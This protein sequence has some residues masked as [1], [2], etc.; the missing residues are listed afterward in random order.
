[1][2][3]GIWRFAVALSDAAETNCNIG[4]HTCTLAHTCTRVSLTCI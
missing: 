4:A 2:R 1:M 3:F